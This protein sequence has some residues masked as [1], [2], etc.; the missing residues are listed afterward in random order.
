MAK[1]SQNRW[2]SI[3]LF[4]R[5]ALIRLAIL[6]IILVILISWA[7]FAMIQMPGESFR[8]QL[9]P[10]TRKEAALRDTL[11]RDVEKL[12]SKIGQRN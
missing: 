6:S 5:A 8:G 11:K 3:Q 9:P 7:W 10:L 4:D 2:F 1:V 12:A